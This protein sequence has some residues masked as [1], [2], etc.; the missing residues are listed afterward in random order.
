[1]NSFFAEAEKLKTRLG[2]YFVIIYVLNN[3][4]ELFLASVSMLIIHT[5]LY[6]YF[7][8]WNGNNFCD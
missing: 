8:I 5:Y 2:S 4:A 7:S 1:M 3:T 6:R